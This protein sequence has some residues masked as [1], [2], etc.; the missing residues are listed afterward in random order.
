MEAM[1][2]MGTF[3]SEEN[4]L[5]SAV[6]DKV[7]RWEILKSNTRMDEFAE[8]IAKKRPEN[9][10]EAVLKARGEGDENSIY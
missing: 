10:T 3:G 6:E 1:V 4:F 8:R 7:R 2:K 9:V 5:K